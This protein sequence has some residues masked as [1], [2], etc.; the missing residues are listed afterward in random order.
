[1]NLHSGLSYIYIKYGVETSVHFTS[2]NFFTINFTVR[3]SAQTICQNGHVSF[4]NVDIQSVFKYDVEMT[5]HFYLCNR[6]LV[7]FNV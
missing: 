5:P 1:M 2:K 7:L 3:L 4:S 6:A